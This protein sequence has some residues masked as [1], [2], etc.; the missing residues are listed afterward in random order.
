[1]IKVHY[2]VQ[3]CDVNSYQNPKR[4][5]GDDRTLLSK[6]SIKSLIDSINYCIEEKNEVE[7]NVMIVE[8][9]CTEDLIDFLKSL[10]ENNNLKIKLHSL[11]KSGIVDSIRYCY[12]WLDKNGVD[13][14]FQVQDDYL[15]SKN[16]IFE[17]IDI[18]YQIMADTRE[19]AIIQPFNDV[20]YWYFLYKN[21]TTPRM[22]A[23]GSKQY[24]IQIYDTSCSFLTS[25]LQFT[26]HWD[27]YDRFFELIPKVTTENNILENRSL[28]YMFTQRNVLGLATINTLSHHMQ[29]Q[30]DLYV[31]WKT[32]W[33]QIEI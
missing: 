14:V 3:T 2:A 29:T 19:H 31:D 4:F 21:Q 24:W 28:N 9:K 26:R 13:L 18:F 6:K 5:C 23:M 22:I 16:A 20:T 12:S 32:I 10:K 15:F 25:H 11:P 30:P 7:H 33:N 17:S 27:L 8:D 1:M